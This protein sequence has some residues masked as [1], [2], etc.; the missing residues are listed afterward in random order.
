MPARIGD[1]RKEARMLGHETTQTFTHAALTARHQQWFAAV[2]QLSP[3]HLQH[4]QWHLLQLD[5]DCRHARFG[6]HTTDGFLR[7]YVACVQRANTLVFGCFIDGCMMGAGDLRS[8]DSFWCDAEAAFSVARPW[9][10]RGIGTF[11]MAY[12]LAA[13]RKL[14]IARAPELR[15]AQSRHA[16]HRREIRRQAAL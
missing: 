2:Q 12:V 10:R 6:D 13:A 3:T 11:L 8:R 16:A 5:E 9:Q 15:R 1:A 4:F 7:Q 14:A